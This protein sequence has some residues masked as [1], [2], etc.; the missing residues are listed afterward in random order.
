M[1][2]RYASL[3]FIVGIDKTDEVRFR[4]GGSVGP[5]GGAALTPSPAL[6]NE[7]ATLELI[8]AYVEALDKHFENVVRALPQCRPA[9]ARS[10]HPAALLRR[11]SWMCDCR[12]L[13]RRRGPTAR[14]HSP[15]PLCRRSCS[16]W[17]R[18]T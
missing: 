11:A 2:R 18:R 1:Y 8:H 15:C 9:A 7:L 17:R 16:I 14:P 10:T 12:A 13:A 6:Q 3:F 5:P 4:A